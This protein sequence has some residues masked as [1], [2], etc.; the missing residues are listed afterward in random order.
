MKRA[1]FGARRAARGSPAPSRRAL[2]T[3]RWS[4]LSFVAAVFAALVSAASPARADPLTAAVPEGHFVDRDGG[5]LPFAPTYERWFGDARREPHYLHA[6]GSLGALLALGSVHYYGLRLERN[7]EDWDDP[8]LKD[9]LTLAAVRFDDNPLSVAPQSAGP[10]G[11]LSLEHT[12]HR[13]HLG[14]IDVTG[15]MRRW[16][17]AGGIAF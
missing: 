17:V 9:R 16:S 14:E 2:F 4:S 5:E 12:H 10:Y 13:S 1:A 8:S 11:R 3:V 6:A 7:R 15:R